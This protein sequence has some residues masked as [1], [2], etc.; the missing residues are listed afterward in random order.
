MQEVKEIK[1]NTVI[2]FNESCTNTGL[3]GIIT[4]AEKQDNG[5]IIYTIAVP[6]VDGTS[7]TDVLDSQNLL[8]VI[9][10]AVFT[11]VEGEDDAK[12]K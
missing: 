9:G 12:S 11:P 10:D 8:E 6:A 3:L 5:D 7:Y 1:V 2:Q 4:K